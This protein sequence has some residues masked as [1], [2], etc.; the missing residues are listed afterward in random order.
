[1]FSDIVKE[2]IEEN[3]LSIEEELGKGGFGIVKK[4]KLLSVCKKL[5]FIA[6]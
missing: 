2:K 3:D 4:M 1:M 6:S 5:Y